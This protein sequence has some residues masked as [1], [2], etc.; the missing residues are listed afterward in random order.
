MWLPRG[1]PLTDWSSVQQFGCGD[2]WRSPSP[3]SCSIFPLSGPSG[4]QSSLPGTEFGVSHG[5][6]SL[7]GSARRTKNI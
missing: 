5:L 2:R 7:R 3:A 6:A 4:L 1:L